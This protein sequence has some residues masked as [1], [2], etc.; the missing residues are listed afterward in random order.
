KN[1]SLVM[2]SSLNAG[3]LSGSPRYNYG[4]ENF[5]I[6]PEV[7][8]KRDA[9]RAVAGRHGVDLRTAAL[10]FSAAASE[11]VALVVGVHSAQQISEDWNSMQAKIPKDFWAELLQ[12]KL[13][14]PN[15][16]LP[17]LDEH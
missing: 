15:A 5:K 13:I 4:K 10:Q 16:H 8:K 7:L 1:V 3:F 6:P 9:L 12:E 14:D 17:K 11:A 2:G